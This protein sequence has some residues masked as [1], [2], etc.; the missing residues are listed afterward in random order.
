MGVD[1]VYSLLSL[2][3]DSLMYFL[4]DSGVFSKKSHSQ[5]RSRAC[6]RAFSFLFGH[7]DRGH[8]S[9]VILSPKKGNHDQFKVP[10]RLIFLWAEMHFGMQGIK[11][12]TL[13]EQCCFHIWGVG[14]NGSY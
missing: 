10:H 2:F 4:E 5:G 6:R 13:S 14:S 11:K 1:E 8:I 12:E 7:Q 3:P 9:L